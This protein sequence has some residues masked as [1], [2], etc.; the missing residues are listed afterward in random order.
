MIPPSAP[1][2][3]GDIGVLFRAVNGLGN[4]LAFGKIVRP[5]RRLISAQAI[6]RREV[7]GP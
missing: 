5:F 6:Y 7:F 2:P 4:Q 1:T 3:E